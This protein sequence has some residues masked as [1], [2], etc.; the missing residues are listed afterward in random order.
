MQEVK[1]VLNVFLETLNGQVDS[2]SPTSNAWLTEKDVPGWTS[3][4]TAQKLLLD[5]NHARGLQ[6]FMTNVTCP[7]MTTAMDEEIRDVMMGSVAGSGGAHDEGGDEEGAEEEPCQDDVDAEEERSRVA[8]MTSR[9]VTVSVTVDTHL[10][11]S[12]IEWKV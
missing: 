11:K 9:S 5:A 7:A 6:F 10:K 8:A 2:I 12:L 3:P 4:P 1:R